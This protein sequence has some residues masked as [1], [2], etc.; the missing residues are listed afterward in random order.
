VVV[1]ALRMRAA[2][3]GSCELLSEFLR[4]YRDAVQ[5]VVNELWSL[6]AKV[7]RKKLH[8]MFYDKLRKWVS[9]HTTLRRYTSTLRE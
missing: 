5:L 9:E 1:E 3:E 4:V 7:S 2:P 8:K 6:N